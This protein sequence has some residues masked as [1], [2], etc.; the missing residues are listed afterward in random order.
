MA[1]AAPTFAAL[2]AALEEKRLRVEEALRGLAPAGR[3]PAVEDAV[4]SSLFAPA[5]RLRPILALLVADVLRDNAARFASGRPLRNVVDK[6]L[7]Y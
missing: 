6:A 4:Q 2:E 1:A 7:W 5:K 3:A